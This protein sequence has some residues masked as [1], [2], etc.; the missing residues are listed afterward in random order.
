MIRTKTMIAMMKNGYLTLL[1]VCLLA[2]CQQAELPQETPGYS[3]RA[4]LFTSP[5]TATRSPN[6][7]YGAFNEGDRVGVLGYA[8]ARG[9]EDYSTS[10]WD[11][12]KEFATPDVFYNEPLTYQGDGAWNYSWST[13]DDPAGGL[14]PWYDDPDYTYAFFAYYPYVQMGHGVSGTLHNDNGDSMGTIELSGENETGDPTITYTLPHNGNST[15]SALDWEV[16]PDFMLAYKVDH[17]EA[18]GAVNLDFRHLLCA[19]EFE[20]NNYNTSSWKSPA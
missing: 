10:P 20:I 8:P 17:R 12:K 3:D 9:Q 2:A 14:H 5:Y 11:T 4:I 16:V 15:Y 1:G 18:D 13:G 6:M 7:R 19:F